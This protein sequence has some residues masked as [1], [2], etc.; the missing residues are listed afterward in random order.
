MIR[1]DARLKM[2]GGFAGLLL[3]LALAGPAFAQS[4]AAARTELYLK[5]GAAEQAGRWEEARI[6]YDGLIGLNSKDE[7]AWRDRAYVRANN[8]DY[9]GVYAD[10]SQA[11]QLNPKDARAY[12]N[13]GS[14]PRAS[15]AQRLADFDT[16]LRLNPAY[17]GAW[18]G[19]AGL[20]DD[21]GDFAGA[22]AAYGA[23]IKL[24]PDNAEAFNGRCWERA[25]MGS[26]LKA[27]EEDC[28]TALRLAPEKQ[29]QAI[30][31]DSRGLVYFRQ[32]RFADAIADYDATLAVTPQ[33]PDTLYR[34]GMAKSATGDAAGA[35]ADMDAALKINPAIDRDKGVALRPAAH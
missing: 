15:T 35:R 32:G 25:L 1:S 19:K 27:A 9:D 3:G 6:A 23:V 30:V 10:F 18:L 33:A 7:D 24:L 12:V 20:Y 14:L 22:V 5:A 29:F 13:R 31:R 17:A 11:I 8:Q 26:E 28:D 4:D 21:S 34:R 16:A 2:S